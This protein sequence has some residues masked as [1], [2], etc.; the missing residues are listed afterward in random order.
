MSASSS[1]ASLLVDGIFAVKPMVAILCQPFI[2]VVIKSADQA[3]SV[4]SWWYPHRVEGGTVWPGV[5]SR[6][7][8]QRT[9]LG[10]GGSTVPA[11]WFAASLPLNTP[12]CRRG[13]RKPTFA[14]ICWRTR[15]RRRAHYLI[16]VESV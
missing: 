7:S 14:G 2:V 6:H 8:C 16:E 10:D 12:H 15:K 9:R 1:V 13:P 3:M 5:D 11:I 4:I